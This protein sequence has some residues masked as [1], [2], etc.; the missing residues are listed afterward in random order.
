MSA[1]SRIYIAIDLKSFYASVECAAKGRDP[2][3]TNLVVADPSRTEKTI[4]LAVSPA[5]KSYKIPGRARLF[6]VIQRVKEINAQRRKNAPQ[7]RFSGSSCSDKEL[8][9]DP[10]LE[11]D[12]IVA[13]P[14]MAEYMRVSTE[15]YNIY[16]RYIA[17]EDIH[18]YS[19]DEVF[20]DATNYLKTYRLSAHELAIKLIREVLNETRITATAGIGTNLYLAKVAMDIVAKHMPADKD[21]VRI[22]EL[23]E[24]SYRQK[25]WTHRPLTD[26]WRIG[27]GYSEKLEANGMYTLGDVA[28]C[29]LGGRY[30]RFNEALLYKL[31]GVNAEL[32]IDHAWGWEPCTIAD[33]KAYKPE[34]NSISSG[35]VL[36]NPY[37][38]EAARLVIREMADLLSLDLVDKG[39]VTDQ[40]VLTV[41]YDIENMKNGFRQNVFHG[42]VTSDHYGRKVPK[43]AHGSINLGRYTSSSKLILNAVSQLFDRIVVKD[44]LVRRMYVVANHVIP[45]KNIPEEEAL[46]LDLFTDYEE[47]A[48]RKE[49]ENSSLSREKELQKAMLSI[50]K[51]FGKNAVLKGMNLEKEATA[52]MRNQQVGGHRA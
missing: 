1:D 34:N 46:Q 36:Q 43:A 17:P 32:L 14:R 20:I 7:R 3:D 47:E 18:V 52:M 8:K 35:Q 42:E 39:L 40:I 10:S 2:L 33:I 51:R 49:K 41:G 29:S 27:R 44:L 5:L 9:S 24:M 48:R 12:F 23:D 11:L 19:I 16:L 37:E 25:L 13:T 28:R 30:D 6:E 45:E 26:F 15:I 38:T 50:K 22:A 21:G 4:C 31:F